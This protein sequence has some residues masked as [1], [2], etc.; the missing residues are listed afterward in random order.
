MSKRVHVLYETDRLGQPHGCSHIRLLRPL[1][2]PSLAGKLMVS[3]GTYLPDGD[4]DAV[5]VERYW[6]P[7]TT[8]EAIDKLASSLRQRGIRLIYTLDDNLLDLEPWSNVASS[9]QR[10]KVARLLRLADGVIVSTE[11]LRQR[12][13]KINPCIEIV[14]NALDERLFLPASSNHSPQPWRDN[15][16]LTIGYMGTLS[17]LQDLMMVLEPLRTVLREAAGQIEFQIVG[18][19][20]EESL[21][22]CFDGLPFRIL[23]TGGKHFY[24]D[25]V[26]WARH[27][28][29]WDLG[30]AP[31]TDNTFT[32]CKSDIKFLDYALLGIPGIY[33][34]VEA[35]RQSVHHG[36]T[37]WLCPNDPPAW[38]ES[39]RHAISH[40]EKRVALSASAF[41]HVKE[42]RMLNTCAGR[43]LCALDTFLVN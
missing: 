21:A 4:L 12:F 20:Q 1:Q 14:E 3:H 34:Q 22:A 18:I 39:L 30:I 13:L 29:R 15:K 37:G 6:R 33:S 11:S 2:H 28:L 24:P 26:A 32:R 43:W 5:I 40:Q 41:K 27:N 16:R 9:V 25:F 36:E 10:N 19:A 8:L 23:D 35:Y 38:I 7:D 17:H 31:L 42:S